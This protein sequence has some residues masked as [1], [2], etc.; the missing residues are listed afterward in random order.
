MLTDEFKGFSTQYNETTINNLVVKGDIPEWLQ[1]DLISNGPAQ[2]E[3]GSMHFNHWIDGFAML[4]KFSFQSGQVQFQNRFLRSKQYTQSRA[5]QHLSTNEFATYAS[6]S[7]IGR[8]KNAIQDVW[9]GSFYD[10]C[11]VN[12]VKIA[13]HYIAMTETNHVIEFNREDLSTVAAFSFSDKIVGQL[14]TAH[15]KIDTFT[16]EIIN[17]VTEIGRQIKYHIYKINSKNTNRELIQTYISDQL[18][19]MHSFSITQ[20]YVILFKSPLSANKFKLLLGLPFNNTL[21][22][23]KNMPSYF[24]I[25]DRRDGRIHEIETSPFVCLHSA[26]AYE[27]NNELILD[28]ICYDVMNPYTN[29]YLSNLRK[30]HPHLAAGALKRYIID[31]QLKHCKEITLTEN[32]HEFPTFYSRLNGKHYNFLYCN[33]MEGNEVK[34]LN[35]IQKINVQSGHIQLWKKDH[36]YPGEAIFVARDNATSEDD[37]VLLSIVYHAGMQCSLLAIIDAITMQDIAEV[38]LPFHLPFGLHGHFYKGNVG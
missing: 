17:V 11:N 14:E 31:R 16:G 25:I 6:R 3:I 26:N 4:K 33:S 24:I 2:F 1:G 34:F 38:F 8:I 18:F 32:K 29:L 35:S 27:N 37:G 7:M 36:Y 19:Y 20:H 13:S 12:I 9:C 15:P 23:Q 10:N 21:F 30:D 28:L 5:L 22:L